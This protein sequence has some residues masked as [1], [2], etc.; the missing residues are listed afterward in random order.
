LATIRDYD[1]IKVTLSKKVLLELCSLL[2]SYRKYIVLV[3]G[4][5][6]YLLIDKYKAKTIDFTHC[7]S[8]DI[9]LALDFK[10]FPSRQDVYKGIKEI[11][12][13]NGYTER[14]DRKGDI[15]PHSFKREVKGIEIQVDFLSPFYGG[16]GKGHRHQIVQ[17]GFLAVKAKGTE[18]AFKDNK[19][20][21]IEGNLPNGARHKTGINVAGVTAIL[22]MKGYAFA[23]DISR[24]KDAYDI[25]SVLRYY[26]DGIVSVKNEIIP[27]LK[28]N[29]V[30]KSLRNIK[31]LFAAIDSVGPTA[32]ADFIIIDRSL[33]DWEFQRRDAYETVQRFLRETELLLT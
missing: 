7:G 18:I 17:D 10:S 3:G 23:D 32:V 9:D 14:K 29:L 16:R 26:K 5:G 1:S 11:I 12:E 31:E 27:F 20:I 33:P 19:L 25:F 28:N 8:L 22:T 24:I 4:W 13:R 30:L 2:K 6:P 21:T 15:I